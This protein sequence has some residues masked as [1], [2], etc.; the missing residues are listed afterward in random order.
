VQ[1]QK[2]PRYFPFPQR[3][4]VREVLGIRL[5]AAGIEDVLDGKIW[6][7]Q[8]PAQRASKRRKDL[9]DIERLLDALPELRSRVPSEILDRLAAS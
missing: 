4:A 8:D 3:A 5:P 6:A 1:I 9:L 2:D 7:A